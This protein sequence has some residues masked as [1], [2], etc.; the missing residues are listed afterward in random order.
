MK[1]SSL[2]IQ[3][4]VCGMKH[5]ENIE[6]LFAIKPDYVGLIFYKKSPRYYEGNKIDFPK[7]IQKVGVFVNESFAEITR[8]I[9][10][11]QLDVVQIHGDESEEYCTELKE[12][13][14]NLKIWKAFSVGPDF[15]MKDLPKCNSIDAFLFDTK[16]V[17]YGGNGV[18]FNWEVLKDFPSDKEIVLSGGISVEDVPLILEIKKEV[19][20]IKIIDI[21]SRFEVEPGLKNIELVKEFSRKL[22]VIK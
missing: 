7:G 12:Y 5:R 19:P 6:E 4:K 21:N 20:Q 11:H 3:L 18:K 16:G 8:M 1:N 15:K 14:P 9:Y 13:F 2:T 10:L 17:N 22:S